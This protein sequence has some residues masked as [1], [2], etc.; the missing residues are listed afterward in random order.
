MNLRAPPVINAN[1]AIT[2]QLD[3]AP[4][5]PILKFLD[6]RHIS[7]DLL[8]MNLRLTDFLFEL[9]LNKL[10]RMDGNNS[11]N[12][13]LRPNLSIFLEFLEHR[14]KLSN[15]WYV[16]KEDRVELRNLTGNER[17]KI[18][19]EL[20]KNNKNIKL[21][22]ALDTYKQSM[23]GLF[24]PNPGPVRLNQHDHFN[25]NLEFFIWHKFYRIFLL[26]INFERKPI[27]DRDL[28]FNR[29]KTDLN[30]WLES[31]LVINR[32]YKNSTT[33]SPYIHIFCYHTVELLQSFG[34]NLNLMNCNGSEK[35][36][37][38]TI[39][40]YHNSSNRNNTDL[41]YLNQ[42]ILKRNR[43]EYIRLEEYDQDEIIFDDEFNFYEDYDN[44]DDQDISIKIKMNKYFM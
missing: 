20:F 38:F 32:K 43:L 37:H 4:L 27:F 33:I 24:G 2:A 11:S 36:N 31:Y 13:A 21:G 25:W 42:M 12:L 8:H 22:P 7:V 23:A 39:M 5:E 1:H 44:D 29:L 34:K 28:F 35:F 9:C 15:A 41:R 14:C 26:L 30:A 3:D 6:F 19:K 17:L 16:S 18:F 10:S 40:Y